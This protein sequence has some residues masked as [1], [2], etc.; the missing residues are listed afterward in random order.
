MDRQR[1]FKA[2]DKMDTANTGYLSGEDFHQLMS[3]TCSPLL[4]QL[5]VQWSILLGGTLM[6]SSYT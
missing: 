6:L 4:I 3:T 2:F 5:A 1:V